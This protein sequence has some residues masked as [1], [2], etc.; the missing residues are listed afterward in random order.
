VT[1]HSDQSAILTL[2]R[3]RGPL[4][5][6]EIADVVYPNGVRFAEDWDLSVA[7]K[8]DLELSRLQYSVEAIGRDHEDFTLWAATT[9]ERYAELRKAARI[10]TAQWL[11]DVRAKMR[12]GGERNLYH[13]VDYAM[14]RA[15]LSERRQIMRASKLPISEL[16]AEFN[17]K[18][19][20]WVEDAAK[21]GL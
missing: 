21:T 17:A 10:A 4:T 9:P 2:L 13:E 1:C 20:G 6:E 5:V 7:D 15:N 19:Q 16:V 11:R 14:Y 12:V 3:A 8:I 18:V